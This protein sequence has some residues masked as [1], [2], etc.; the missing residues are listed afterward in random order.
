MKRSDYYSV[1]E[2]A[3]EICSSTTFVYKLLKEGVLPDYR[4][5]LR[6]LIPKVAVVNYIANM[7]MKQEKGVG[8][9]GR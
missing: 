2:A 8:G 1:R 6:H 4:V 3:E 9:H 5:G 7:Q